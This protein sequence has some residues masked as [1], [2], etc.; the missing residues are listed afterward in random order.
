MVDESVAI[1]T[2]AERRRLL[3]VLD[4]RQRPGSR[5]QQRRSEGKPTS[6]LSRLVVCGSCGGHLARALAGGYRVLRCQ[7]RSCPAAV[8][9]TEAPL[10][11]Y[12]TEAV[13]AERGQT[14]I[15]EVTEYRDDRP[16]LA[17]IEEALRA[18]SAQL[19]STDDRGEEERLLAQIATLKARRAEA[20]SAALPATTKR[21]VTPT[22]G[23]QTW[24]QEFAE[25]QEADDLA[26]A[27]RLLRE[28]VDKI[29]VGSTG[30]R[31]RVPLSERVLVGYTPPGGLD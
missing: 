27:A 9:I 26:G 16:E 22:R 8:T 17:R 30:G 15:H 21:I 5:P 14:R 1:L 20:R 23:Q 3:D 10:L 29:T 25:A 31:R 6:L 7:N 4:A 28:Q 12:V 24:G 11:V 2:L 19:A 13:L 18:A